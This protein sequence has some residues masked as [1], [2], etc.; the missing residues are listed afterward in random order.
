MLI[1]EFTEPKDNSYHDTEEDN[2]RPK[3]GEVR[4]SKLTL[5]MINKLRKMKEVESFE[6]AIEREKLRKQYQP[7]AEPAV[8][9]L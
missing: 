7:P 4:K 8:P 3:W 5:S 2:S 9:G 6:R 1:R